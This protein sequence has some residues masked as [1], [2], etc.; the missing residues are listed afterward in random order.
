MNVNRHPL[1]ISHASI[2]QQNNCMHQAPSFSGVNELKNG[3]I[4]ADGTIIQAYIFYNK[5]IR[6][7]PP[8]AS[9][10]IFNIDRGPK[11]VRTISATACKEQQNYV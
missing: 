7:L 8:E 2:F 11:V 3:Q 10:S 1:S 6:I 9:R 5:I 4:L